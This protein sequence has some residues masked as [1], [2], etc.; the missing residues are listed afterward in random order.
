MTLLRK[1]YEALP[2]DSHRRMF[3]DAAL[4]LH[5]RLSSH[6]TSLWAAQLQL[7]D[8]LSGG[9]LVFRGT[10]WQSRRKGFRDLPHQ[11]RSVQNAQH[12]RKAADSMLA[13]LV[14]HSLVALQDGSGSASNS[15]AAMRCESLAAAT[16]KKS[17]KQLAG[18]CC[19]E[20]VAV[21]LLQSWTYTCHCFLAGSWSTTAC[22]TWQA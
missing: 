11:Q 8:S 7:D 13:D 22:K 20:A 10:G 4:L 19:A 2:S 21:N 3:L 6:L 5:S 12:C 17:K 9:T 1:S 16:C 14:R 15:S 18:C